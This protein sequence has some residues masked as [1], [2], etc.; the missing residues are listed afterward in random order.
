MS[1]DHIETH[2]RN[3]DHSDNAIANLALL[4]GHCHDEVHR[5]KSARDK[6][7]LSEEPDEAKVS[8]PVL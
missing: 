5:T 4:H 7:L 6:S 8:C 3:G 2:H 1:D